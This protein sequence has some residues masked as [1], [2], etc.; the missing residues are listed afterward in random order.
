MSNDINFTKANLDALAAPASDRV[1]YQD[2]RISALKLRVTSKGVKTFSVFKRVKGGTAIRSTLG[3]YPDMSIE[4]AR[5]QAATILAEIANGGN[6]TAVRRSLKGEPTFAE[7][8]DIYLNRHAK[9]HKKTWQND[10]QRYTQY[11]LKPLGHKKLSTIDKDL[12]MTLL[13]KI[14]SNGHPTVANRVSSLLS[15]VFN[16][17]IEWGITSNNP[18]YKLRK[19]KETSRDRFIQSDELERFFKKLNEMTNSII[20]DYILLSL[21]T[22]ARRDN[23]LC[24]K[25]SDINFT[26]GTWRI[27]ITKNGTPQ[28][29]PLPDAAIAILNERKKLAATTDIFVLPGTGATGHLASPSKAWEKLR[30]KADLPDL[31]LHDLRRTM[32][33][34]QAKTGASLIVIGKSLNHKSTQTTAI[35]ARLDMDPVR[36]SMNTAADAMLKAGGIIK[37]APAKKAMRYHMIGRNITKQ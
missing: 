28:N 27:P 24:I 26:D 5:R 23:V 3:K 14:T 35:Y 22:G 2:T 6:P 18:C 15:C 34:W 25:W 20:R 10:Q 37:S 12:V 33:S 29:I 13:S 30:T 31:R 4:Q 11:L 32:G 7:L 9:P 21:L 36:A 19:N 1:E 17:G 8:F 16:R